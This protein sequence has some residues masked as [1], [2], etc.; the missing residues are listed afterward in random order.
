[1]TKT[2]TAYIK[3]SFDVRNM[4]RATRLVVLQMRPLSTV[5]F[6]RRVMTD[7]VN[8][9]AVDFRAFHR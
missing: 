8:D 7:V 1:M 4:M 2:K 9:M 3:V 6:I 5:N